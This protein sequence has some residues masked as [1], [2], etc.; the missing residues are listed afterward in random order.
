MQ[1]LLLISILTLAGCASTHGPADLG[2]GRALE[3]DQLV[4]RASSSAMNENDA[5]L[6]AQGM[7]LEDLSNECSLLPHATRLEDVYRDAN[8]YEITLTVEAR[9]TMFDC[10][11]A[12]LAVDVASTRASASL[13]LTRTLKAAQDGRQQLPRAL[14]LGGTEDPGAV[15]ERDSHWDDTTYYYALRQSLAYLKQIAT[16]APEEALQSSRPLRGRLDAAITQ[17]ARALTSMEK[18]NSALRTRALTWSQ[19]PDR[20]RILR[21]DLLERHED[22]AR[23]LKEGWPRARAA[24]GFPKSSVAVH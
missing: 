9:V 24:Q 18:S 21:P 4:Y 14:A 2:P 20:P 16:L 8:A 6:K 19:L 3:G 1:R 7:V 11:R 13:G 12:R 15:L 22:E 5:R 17:T 23:A 10:T